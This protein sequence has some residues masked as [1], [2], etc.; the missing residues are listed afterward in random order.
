VYI[1]GEKAKAKSKENVVRF[2]NSWNF[3]PFLFAVESSYT[4]LIFLA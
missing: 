3:I 4:V 1:L 2:S